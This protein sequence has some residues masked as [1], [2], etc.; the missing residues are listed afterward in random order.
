MR[1]TL[2]IFTCLALLLF[3]KIPAQSGS[4]QEATCQHHSDPPA[5][6]SA[7]R[8]IPPAIIGE[9]DCFGN[10]L[11]LDKPCVKKKVRV[12]FH[13]VQDAQGGTNFTTADANVIFPDMIAQANAMLD[14]NQQINPFNPPSP[15]PVMPTK[16]NLEL[17]GIS[18]YQTTEWTEQDDF[19]AINLDPTAVNIVLR[20][21]WRRHQPAAPVISLVSQTVPS[22]CG[23]NDG[24]IEITGL[25]PSLNYE[26]FYRYG[27]QAIG[28]IAISGQSSYTL[29]ALASGRYQ[30]IHVTTT[31]VIGGYSG[32][33]RSNSLDA[34]LYVPGSTGIQFLAASQ[35]TACN[36]NNGAFTIW[37]LDNTH[38]Y[39][40]FYRQN[41]LQMPPVNISSQSF[42]SLTNLSPGYYSDIQVNDLT[43]GCR[44]NQ[45]AID[46]KA[47]AGLT[48]STASEHTVNCD[49]LE[50]VEISVPGINNNESVIVEYTFNGAIASSM[51]NATNDE[52]IRLTLNPGYYQGLVVIRN[53][54]RSNAINFTVQSDCHDSRI[55]GVSAGTASNYFEVWDFAQIYYQKVP[56]DPNFTYD[57]FLTSFSVTTIHEMGHNLSLRHAFENHGCSDL[58]QVGRGQ[59]NNFMDWVYGQSIEAFSPCQIEKMHAV[60]DRPSMADVSGTCE[61]GDL[62]SDLLVVED[63]A[64]GS[65]RIFNGYEDPN[66]QVASVYWTVEDLAA[67]GITYSYEEYLEFN[68]MQYAGRT[69]RICGYVVDLDGCEGIVDCEDVV[70][71]ESFSCF[72]PLISGIQVQVDA[73]GNPQ[74]VSTGLSSSNHFWTISSQNGSG[75]VTPC[76]AQSQIHLSQLAQQVGDVLEI[77]VDVAGPG[78][79]GGVCT[80]KV[81]TTLI[82]NP[83]IPPCPQSG[84]PGFFHY[85]ERTA[86][87]AYLNIKPIDFRGFAYTHIWRIT[88]NANG[89]S[90]TTND[91]NL[92]LTDDDLPGLELPGV[93]LDL[94]VCHYVLDANT[95]C[96]V[97]SECEDIQ[98]TCTPS[99]GVG[100]I[101]FAGYNSS[102]NILS[103]TF[104]YPFGTTLVEA[105]YIIDGMLMTPLTIQMNSTPSLNIYQV[106]F[107]VPNPEPAINVNLS[108]LATTGGDQRFCTYDVRSVWAFAGHGDKP[109]APAAVEGTL[110][111]VRLAPNPVTSGTAVLHLD[112]SQA[113]PTQ[114]TLIDMAGKVL[115]K[116]EIRHEAGSSAWTLE[117]DRLGAGIYF[118]RAEAAW[119]APLVQKV[120]VR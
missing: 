11:S 1:R 107:F 38:N 6:P 15:P 115:L 119:H 57:D 103:F 109:K 60:L 3:L 64:A 8:D 73:A 90:F 93:A 63:Q 43:T 21:D 17:A 105:Q 51:E 45:L 14:D 94:T 4:S 20:E 48:I 96:L 49:P 116:Q 111:A 68:A 83:P 50:S 9:A 74:S 97:G 72:P 114:V 78:P 61:N 91:E 102:T 32:T 87:A 33:Q 39:R 37:G 13:I 84:D 23:S 58:P 80:T 56:Q 42:F 19:N 44:S 27:G 36:S 18:D 31:N 89:F 35:P 69:L 5:I 92:A 7:L 108:T 86:Q 30:D 16:I 26:L 53:G 112:A 12:H 41:G 40:L 113:G 117:L 55:G 22:T 120:L 54:C 79:N 66:L 34:T 104:T 88:D 76:E 77:C 118:L 81:C 101:G 70:F 67:P 106:T 2:F 98:T 62:E 24:S 52:S 85:V 29:S 59:S 71:P 99:N 110:D 46:L 65:V 82:V 28:P 95:N 75:M 10:A 25:L 47:P 100:Q